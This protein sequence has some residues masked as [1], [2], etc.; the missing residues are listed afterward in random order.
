MMAEITSLPGE[1]LEQDIGPVEVAQAN[2]SGAEPVGQVTALQG[3]AFI[4][5]TDGTKVQA[6]DGA[7]I[8]QGDSIETGADGAVGITFSDQSTFSLAD[9]GQMTIDEMVFDPASQS[10]TSALSVATGVFTFVSG[11]IAKTGVEAMTIS[12][13][14]ATIGV[15]G[16]SGGGRGGPEGT[17][18]T[19]TMFQDAGGGTGEMVITTQGGSQTMNTPN[20]TSQISSAFVP[21]TQPVILPPGAVARFYARAAAVSSTP[22]VTQPTDGGPAGGGDANTAGT[23]GPT[24]AGPTGDG[25]PA[26]GAVDPNAPP[27]AEQAFEQVLAQGGS[28]EDAMAAAVDGAA[29]AELQA[30]LAVNPNQFGTTGND[31][32]D[33]IINSVLLNVTGGIDPLSAGTGKGPGFSQFS[34]TIFF[35]DA[36]AILQNDLQGALG[37]EG[38]FFGPEGPIFITPGFTDPFA[39]FQ[40]QFFAADGVFFIDTGD[41]NFLQ[42]GDLTIFETDIA[43][44]IGP[45]ETTTFEETLDG[46]TGNDTLVG[47]AGSTNF[48]MGFNASG[49]TSHLGGTDTVD[50]GGGTNQLTFDDLNDLKFVVSPDGTIL[51]KGSITVTTLNGGVFAGG[52]S[53]T[54]TDV[55]QFL[56]ADGVQNL[57][58]GFNSGGTSLDTSG[59]PTSESD[60]VV[61]PSLAPGETGEAHIGTS[62]GETITINTANLD[63]ALVFA[64]GG[65]DTIAINVD[66]DGLFIGGFSSTENQDT[67]SDSIADANINVF[68]YAGLALPTG[69]TGLQ[70][71]L[72]GSSDTLVAGGSNFGGDALVRDNATT[73]T[74]VNNLWDVGSFIGSGGDDQILVNGGTSGGGFALIDGGNGNDSFVLSGAARIGTVSGGA[75]TNTYN[76]TGAS[77]VATLTGGAG[78]DTIRFGLD[79]NG[80]A[81][82]TGGTIGNVTLV[83]TIQ[84]GTG[85]DAVTLGAGGNTVSVSGTIE[86]FAGGAGSDVL[87]LASTGVT[88]GNV[89]LIETI[90]GGVGT[91]AVT[92]GAGGQTVTISAVETITGG[93]GADAVTVT[94]AS[95]DGGTVTYD[96]GAASDTL[97]INGSGSLTLDAT[98]LGNIT[99]WENWT[100]GSNIATSITTAAGNVATSGALT[101]NFAALTSAAATVN[102]SA[103]TDGLITYTGGNGI[104][105][106]TVS[107]TMIDGAAVTLTGGTG[108]SDTLRLSG[109][110]T[111][112][113]DSE[114]V[115]ITAWETWRLN[116]G[117]NHDLT[118]NAANVAS[119]ATLSFISSVTGA[120]TA[121]VDATLETDGTINYAGGGGADTLT[122]ASAMLEGAVAV[123][124][125][126]GSASDTL[127]FIGT[128]NLNTTELGSIQEFETWVLGSNANY[129]LVMASINAFVTSGSLTIDATAV[130]SGSTATIDTQLDTTAPINY[131][132][133]AG[134]DNLTVASA[135]IDGQT[136]I[137]NGNAGTD[138][139]TFIGT[140][141][142]SAIE[143]GNISNFETWTLASNAT[144]NLTLST[145][146][147][148]TGTLTID[149]TAINVNGSFGT[150]DASAETDGGSINLNVTTSALDTGTATLTGGAGTSDVLS[151]QSSIV[152]DATELANISGFETWTIATDG[153]YNLTLADGNNAATLLTINGAAAATS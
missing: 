144:Y 60:T 8:Y 95:V 18:N 21:P 56:F 111:T 40:G 145:V 32:M 97:T 30:V 45:I 20:Q 93:A 27:T 98:E 76:I 140:G 89:Q 129:T 22:I 72:L 130:L 29:G 33:N 86:T 81:V 42:A 59:A 99:A 16:T 2:S 94:G 5:R 142:L 109:D 7:P 83:E 117:G 23:A 115:N 122:V 139:L 104:N 147:A 1:I 110:N 102:I 113:I 136:V 36:L 28:L 4:V 134:T 10:G 79:A 120:N 55:Q 70:V 62:A 107:S 131:T 128:A 14:V 148:G 116:D 92:L 132:G 54:Y 153:T 44:F 67:N 103:E 43:A 26:D 133:G 118:L 137:L 108:T 66:A 64:K 49:G 90:N 84:G 100:F 65:G 73:A 112:L 101:M 15:R 75:G 149:A 63:G 126:N 77:T 80:N 121:T 53:I 127:T 48:F 6:S 51:D 39:D 52:S 25:A 57:G 150:F 17:P 141:T 34:N 69:A 58:T 87:N 13:P 12:T 68:T 71:N 114:L 19:F 125:G 151:L 38:G 46:T 152:L 47:A 78:A 85:T 37:G 50:G 146:N 3:S 135:M 61:F 31:V 41:F 88:L 35:D 124:D 96:G 91:D 11:Q 119:A 9:A 74:M 123:I 82:A 138:T 106:L 105:D 143:L 24:D